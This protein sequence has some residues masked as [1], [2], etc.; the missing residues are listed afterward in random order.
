MAILAPVF[1]D[2]PAGCD[3]DGKPWRSVAACAYPGLVMRMSAAAA[4][5]FFESDFRFVTGAVDELCYRLY[6]AG[7]FVAET[8]EV[9]Y[10]LDAARPFV[11]PS[12]QA[13]ADQFALEWLS[14]NHGPDWEAEFWRAAQGHGVAADRFAE[15]R[16]T[17]ESVGSASEASAAGMPEPWPLV[18]DATYLLFAWPRYDDRAEL[19][20]LLQEFV[21]PLLGRTDV[22][23]CLRHD[24]ELDGP[25]GRAIEAL[26]HSFQRVIGPS[27][28]FEVLLVDDELA[29]ED[30]PRLGRSVTCVL[31]LPSS[32]EEPRRELLEKLAAP[33]VSGARDL[34]AVLPGLFANLVPEPRYTSEQLD[35]VDW[36]LVA[37]IKDLHPWPYPVHVGNLAVQPGVGTGESPDRIARR[38]AA[39]AGRLIFGVGKRLELRDRSVLEL[40]AGCAY[41]SARFTERGARRVV[42][43]ESDAR[44][45]AQAR[46]YWSQ[47]PFLPE[48]AFRI[49]DGDLSA[50]ATW[51]D[52]S[53]LGPHDVTVCVGLPP[54]IQARDEFLRRAVEVTRE[55]L[56]LDLH[57]SDE[58][59]FRT[60]LERLGLDVEPIHEPGE[61][62]R[63][64]LFARRRVAQASP[65]QARAS[66]HPAKSA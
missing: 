43:V 10:Q 46:L 5:G 66:L 24:A 38:T 2:E 29:A 58:D 11:H 40:G 14:T 34:L 6:G 31:P 42:A 18:T 36:D 1:G 26:E 32:S 28:E 8:D 56:I 17:W 19:D 21:R 57:A 48:D 41:W 54:E 25:Q 16:E 59:A 61:P 53:A 12:E 15:H 60:R 4:V 50:A 65:A 7:W 22:C 63:L 13:F 51:D 33:V 45:S 52:I 35:T 55:A 47:N 39:L 30:W 37:E 27:S 44:L 20:A 62:E 3:E 23:L 49:L 9:R 64:T